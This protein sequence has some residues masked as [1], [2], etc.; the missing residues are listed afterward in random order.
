MI[1]RNT[2]KTN[3]KNGSIKYMYIRF[4][5][6]YCYDHKT[7]SSNIHSS[8]LNEEDIPG[9]DMGL[10]PWASWGILL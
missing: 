5:N 4:E 9:G 1:I 8:L 10:F 6:R 7:I 3:E 2:N